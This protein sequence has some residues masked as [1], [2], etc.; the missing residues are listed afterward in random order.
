LAGIDFSDKVA[1]IWNIAELL[2]GPYKPHQYGRIIIPMTVLRRLDCVLE[3]TK[4][5]VLDRAKQL[6][7]G[8]ITHI[9]P[10]LERVSG[11]SFYN[12]SKFTFE[13]L[14]GDP[15]DIA[16]NLIDYING[17]SPKAKDIIENFK[18]EAEIANLDAKDRLYGLVAKFAGIDL[19]PDKVSNMEMGYIFEELIRRF[20]ESSNE[21]AG[22]HFTPREVIRLMVNL[23]LA[24]DD[25]TLTTPG[26]VKTLF[27]PA[28]GT[29]GM[30][31]VAQDWVRAHNSDADLIAFGQEWNDESYAICGSDMLIKGEN[32]DNVVF[33]DSFTQDGHKGQRFDYML[34]NPPFGVDWKEQRDSIANEAQTLGFDGRFG[35]GTPRVSDGSLLFLQHMLSKM[36]PVSEGGSRLAIVF[37]GSPLFTGDA[38]SGESK[39]RRWIIESDWLEA[40]VALP[41]QMFY[42]T[43]IN[44]YI[45][46]LTNRKADERR[47]KVQLIDATEMYTKMRKTLGNKRKELAPEHIH[48][49]TR[50]H[51]EFAEEEHSKV[52]ANEDFGFRKVTVERPLRLNFQTSPERIALL[53]DETAFVR[54]AQSKK[55]DAQAKVAEERAGRETQRAIRSMLSSIPAMLVTNR[56]RFSDELRAAEQAAGLRLDAQLRKAALS[57]LSERDEAADICTD[58]KGNPEADSEL[59][60]TESVP[61]SEDIDEYFV[62]E[63][64]PY[65]PD[66]WIN[67]SIR[68][69]K[70]GCVGKVGYEINFN[71]FFYVYTPARPLDQIEADLR[72]VEREILD[73][74][75]QVTE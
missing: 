35:A 72:A 41:D 50:I 32:I 47:G 39:I 59:R 73:L 61:L 57:A 34:A 22:D 11:H 48:E 43:G 49:I 53:D 3:P 71:R 44:T 7:G 10:I 17:F 15:N 28:C 37:N 63:V 60:D 1:F 4:D 20:N 74:L 18:F 29:G 31:S 66:A 42:N 21:T 8:G 68:D 5:A 51:G 55:K 27:D 24:P 67:K 65:V 45:W 33:G 23:I 54:L 12:T 52:F 40:V 69:P 9:E 16:A 75:R 70:D 2:R 56:E 19:H 13:R 30:L 64:L 6:Q 26:I 25:E 58:S 38:G 62:H 14:K 36:K 46:V